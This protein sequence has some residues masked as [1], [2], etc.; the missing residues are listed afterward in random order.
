M[1]TSHGR[2]GFTLLETLIVMEVLVIVLA[3]G[4]AVMTGALR[5]WQA[6]AAAQM[7]AGQRAALAALFR[8][9]VRHS[10]AA[11]E[12]LEQWTAG[13][14]C[15]ILQ[16]SNDYFLVYRWQDGRLVRRA[17]PGGEMQFVPLG[18]EGAAVEFM[19]PGSG[20]LLTL[21]LKAPQAPAAQ[22]IAA[23]LGGDQR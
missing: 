8:A 18:A 5:V 11:P 4:M 20:G 7:E 12:R 1:T 15:L 2:R 23:T 10:A 6:S 17:V 9:D 14:A 21:R 22:E 16:Q 13:P 3:L 19:R